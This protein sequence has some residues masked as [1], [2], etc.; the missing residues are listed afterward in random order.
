MVAEE[1][2]FLVL[3]R[4]QRPGDR[5]PLVVR[6]NACVVQRAQQGPEMGCFAVTGSFRLFHPSPEVEHTPTQLGCHFW[7]GLQAT[8]ALGGG[9]LYPLEKGVSLN[10]DLDRSKAGP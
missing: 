3:S 4:W 9:A 6:G 7:L 8:L 10:C 5:H 2:K 1:K